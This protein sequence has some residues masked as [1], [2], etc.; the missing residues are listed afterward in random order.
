[1]DDLPKTENL[2]LDP[3]LLKELE[4][5]RVQFEA[6]WQAALNGAEPPLL[7]SY[8]A[9]VGEA[10]RP[11]V[12]QE[13]GKIQAH[14]QQVAGFDPMADRGTPP[15]ERCDST[16]K[17]AEEAGLGTRELSRVEVIGT[18]V[19]EVMFDFA[20][21]RKERRALMRRSRA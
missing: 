4:T 7:Q 13:L 21:I 19:K 17:L 2:T 20:R 5:L 12:R 9:Q 16:L 3:C 8:L 10:D 14:Y 18:P 1:M 11:T 15:F 6:A